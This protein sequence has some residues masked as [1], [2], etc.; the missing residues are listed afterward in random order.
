MGGARW[1]VEITFIKDGCSRSMHSVGHERDDHDTL[2]T[3]SS[4][5]AGQ[6][7]SSTVAVT[8]CCGHIDVLRYLDASEQVEEDERR[9]SVDCCSSTSPASIRARG[10]VRNINHS[11]HLV[12]AADM[13]DTTIMHCARKQAR[14]R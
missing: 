4:K 9:G 13:L 11:E 5:C 2:Q 1:R 6:Y 3:W 7:G 10:S 12:A 14:S 8:F